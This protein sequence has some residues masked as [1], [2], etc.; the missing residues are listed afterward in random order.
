MMVANSVELMWGPGFIG[1]MIATAFYGI[2]FGQYIFYL[3]SFPE[4]PKR[5][6]LFIMMVL[7]VLLT[8][9]ECTLMHVSQ[10]SRNNTR[11]CLDRDVLVYPHFVP[12]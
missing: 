2:A 11:I 9:L 5:L 10:L 3:R 4:D 8:M 12:S 7:Y 6:K 1:F